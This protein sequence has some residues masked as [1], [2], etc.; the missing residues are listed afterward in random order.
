VDPAGRDDPDA[1]A[2][3]FAVAGAHAD[4]DADHAVAVGHPDARAHP[5]THT[6]AQPDEYTAHEPDPR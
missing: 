2:D 3:R 4:T 1:H 6:Q 5:Q